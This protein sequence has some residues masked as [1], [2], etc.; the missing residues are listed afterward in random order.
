VLTA[1]TSML[2]VPGP[3]LTESGLTLGRM[4]FERFGFKAPDPVRAFEER[5]AGRARANQRALG[6][7]QITGTPRWASAMRRSR[8]YR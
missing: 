4:A 1:P 3:S 5:R 8:K 7:G 2:G 6:L